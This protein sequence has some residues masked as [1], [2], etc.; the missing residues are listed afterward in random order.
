MKFKD[1][2]INLVDQE[3]RTKTGNYA[4]ITAEFGLNEY[5]KDGCLVQGSLNRI[6]HMGVQGNNGKTTAFFWIDVVSL[7]ARSALVGW[8]HTGGILHS[9]YICDF[10]LS[11]IIYASLIYASY[12]HI[13]N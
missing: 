5:L 11:S 10:L 9:I 4:L 3:K 2:P 7:S 13:Q 6:T 8:D 1:L 12:Q